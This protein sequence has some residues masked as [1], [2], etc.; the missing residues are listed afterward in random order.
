MADD[1]SEQRPD[2]ERFAPV[3]ITET[4][5]QRRRH[6]LQQRIQGD[7]ECDCLWSATESF[8]VER[9]NRNDESEAEHVDEHDEKQHRHRRSL[10]ES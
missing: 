10:Q 1:G 8:D 2:H 5:D 7:D 3:S 4:P 9:Q 6:K